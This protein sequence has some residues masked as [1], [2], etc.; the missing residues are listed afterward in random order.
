MRS[1]TMVLA[2]S[3]ACIAAAADAEDSNADRLCSERPGLTTSAC[4]TAPGRLQSETALA[5][6]T[7]AL[8][9]G[10]RADTILIGDTLIR[11]GVGG[12]TELRLGFTPYGFERDRHADGRVERAG[13]V[14]DATVGVKTSIVE[15]K[16]DTGLAMSMI[17]TALLPVGRRP[18]GAGDWGASFQLPVTY[19]TSDKVSLQVTPLVAAAVDDD[20]RGRHALYG[21]AVEIEYS[22]SEAVKAA[23]SAQLTRDDDPDPTVR[24][25]PA[26]SSVAFSW[27]P[28]H[29]LQLDLGTNVGLNRAAPDIEVFAGV[30]HRF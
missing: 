23:V 7:L 17:A 18:I 16:E 8:G 24:G 10:E 11:Y 14:G 12:K 6:W 15:R 21:S 3:V 1:L 20:G 29:N 22:L 4:I 9:D 25:T 30:S 27:Q 28:S 13:R 26:L 2:C 19:R 5:D